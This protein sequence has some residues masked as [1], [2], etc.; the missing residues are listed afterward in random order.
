MEQGFVYRVG[1]ESK[2]NPTVPE[3]KYVIWHIQGGLGKNIAATALVKDIKEKYNDRKFIL[4]CSWP[5]VFLNNPN[6]DRVYQ[7][8]QT[9]YFYENYIENKDVIVFKHEPYYQTGHI[10]RKNH[11][12]QSWCELLGLEYKNQKPVIIPNYVQK[13]TKGMWT[14]NKPIM[15]IQ[16]GGGPFD[17][18]QGL[19]SWTRDMPVEV[20]QEVVKKFNNQYHIIQVTRP[21]GYELEGVERV[22]NKLSNMELFALLVMSQKRVLID[23][24]LQHAA[25]ALNLPST[26]LWI[27]TSAVNFGYQLHTNIQAKLP[28]KASQ[29]IGSYVFD[30]QFQNNLHECPYLDV[31]E[32]FDI[33]Q[34]LSSI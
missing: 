33:N 28:K 21:G 1:E 27:G 14:R 26:V 10:T 13:M 20:A 12:I 31:N 24:C 34:L 18:K 4:V 11:I 22:E 29:L 6:I 32:M 2:V 23:S 19:Y 16:T 3:E 5:E 30:Y 17:P 25:S 9:P 15:V 8:G 7:L